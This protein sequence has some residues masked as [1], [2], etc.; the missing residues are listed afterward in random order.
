MHEGEFV[1]PAAM[2]PRQA[3][4]RPDQPPDQRLPVQIGQVDPQAVDRETVPGQ[5][6]RDDLAFGITLRAKSRPPWCSRSR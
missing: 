6:D 1:L 2:P 4:P 3:G 5:G